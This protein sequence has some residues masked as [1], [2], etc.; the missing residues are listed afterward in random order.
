ML[1]VTC[2]QHSKHSDMDQTSQVYVTAGKLCPYPSFLWETISWSWNGL[3]MS[4][5]SILYLLHLCLS[6]AELFREVVPVFQSVEGWSYW[7]QLPSTVTA[8]QRMLLMRW[9]NKHQKLTQ[10]HYASTFCTL[11]VACQN[12]DIIIFKSLMV[13]PRAHKNGR[14]RACNS[15][16]FVT[17]W[18]LLL[19]LKI[20][21]CTAHAC[22]T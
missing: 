16:K 3:E 20:V 15:V 10:S 7:T 8:V 21:T 13:E 5:F 9:F 12:T 2:G 1:S 17:S 19:V 22:I 6:F 11:H 18:N 4:I 14:V